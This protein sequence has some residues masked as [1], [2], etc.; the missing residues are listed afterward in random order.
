MAH[1]ELNIRQV[2]TL[3]NI[4]D[5]N[6]KSHSKNRFLALLYMFGF[7]TSKDQRV[8]AEAFSKQQAKE[9]MRKQ[10]NLVGQVLKSEVDVS[11]ANMS[12]LNKTAKHVL[13]ILSTCSLMDLASGA[14]Y[15]SG[16]VVDSSYDGSPMSTPRAL[17]QDE[18]SSWHFWLCAA[19]YLMCALVGIG[20]LIASG[21]IRAGDRVR[22]A[23]VVAATPLVHDEA[24]GVDESDDSDAVLRQDAERR[25]RYLHCSLSEA[26]DPETWMEVRHHVGGSSSEETVP[27]DLGLENPTAANC[28]A[29][30]DA[31]HGEV[32]NVAICYFLL[33]R[34]NRRLQQ[35]T[36]GGAD[37]GT[38]RFYADAFDTLH[39]S[40]NRFASGELS[41]D[42][43]ETRGILKH[44]A[45]FSP[46]ANSPTASMTMEEI[47]DVLRQHDDSQH[48]DDME[49][50]G[51]D[52]NQPMDLDHG[53]NGIE[54]NTREVGPEKPAAVHGPLTLQDINEQRARV[55]EEIDHHLA[56]AVTQ[57]D[58]W[59]WEAQRDWWYAVP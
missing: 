13:R 16:A 8:G 43:L 40:F 35:A 57:E 2:P 10:V 19:M 6:T 48:L 32:G 7:T 39:N 26:S 1:H 15:P 3:Q 37:D 18:M 55:L 28:I 50:D 14:M 51:N 29:A 11:G 27:E 30:I 9:V 47:A 31:T 54:N 46:R 56:E 45:V 4:A 58:I 44:F 34:T 24:D 20:F 52:E 38:I 21:A 23:E 17:G 41:D 53:L 59:Y 5:L 49:V 33:E 12:G 36:D 25:E 22:A 42:S